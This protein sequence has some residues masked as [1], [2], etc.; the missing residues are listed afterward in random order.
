[1][2]PIVVRAGTRAPGWLPKA[3]MPA[4][5]LSTPTPT[6]ALTRLKISLEIEAV[7]PETWRFLTAGVT[8]DVT[9]L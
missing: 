3:A 6:I 8:A 4:G 1:M 7:P 2:T 9:P 5:K